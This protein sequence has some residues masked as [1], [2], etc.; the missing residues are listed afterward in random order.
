MSQFALEQAL[1]SATRLDSSISMGRPRAGRPRPLVSI[2]RSVG[3]EAAV[4]TTTSSS[5]RFLS[6]SMGSGMNRSRSESRLQSHSGLEI[7]VG[8]GTGASRNRSETPTRSCSSLMDL[9]KTPTRGDRF[10]PNRSTTDIEYA[11]HSISRSR[12]DLTSSSSNHESQ[13]SS[14]TE[15]LRRQTMNEVLQG[16]DAANRTL[17]GGRILSYRNKAPVPNETHVNNLKVVYSS[18]KPKVQAAAKTRQVVSNPDKI[19]DA[20]DLENDFYLHLLDWSSNNHLAVALATSLFIWN[21]GDGSIAEL[22]TRENDDDTVCSVRWVK[23]GNILAVSN[24]AGAIELWDVTDSKFLRR[25][26]AHSDRVAVMDWNQYLLASGCRDGMVHIN[27]VRISDHLAHR[28]EGHSQEVCGMAWS[29]NGRYLA[30]GS[31]DNLV[32][33]WDSRQFTTPLHTLN[34]HQSAIKA[35]SWC[36][37]QPN[38][39]ATGGGT[40]DRTIKFWNATSGN[41]IQ[42]V[43]SGSQVSSLVWNSEYK[44]LIS[45]HGYQHNQLTIWKYPDMTKVSDLKGHTD[46]VLVMVPSPDGTTVASAAA[47]ETIRLW[48]VWPPIVK[49]KVVKNIAKDS[50]SLLSQRVIR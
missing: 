35:L 21:A 12:D 23:E 2:K 28:L 3:S 7:R 14:L 47:D 45:A 30:T 31:N 15:Q 8:G 38:V 20:P 32:L 25:M 36:P 33:V 43:H 49:K 6:A 26:D 44:E 16:G 29:A 9:N 46:R 48:K 22:F 1:Q 19:L 41:L 5:N 40:S 50:G 18:S 13:V 34:Q 39:L 10:I 4:S 17:N 37:W 42:S 27:D 11:Q 24:L